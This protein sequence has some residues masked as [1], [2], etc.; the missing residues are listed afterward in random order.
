MFFSKNS[1]IQVR[2]FT[3]LF[4]L[5]PRASHSEIEKRRRQKLNKSIIELLDILPVGSKSKKP[6]K[7]T[8]LKIAVQH[9]R[10]L[11]ASNSILSD[12][13]LCQNYIT[14]L[15]LQSLVLHEGSNNFLI[16]IRL[17]SSKIIYVSETCTNCIG[18]KPVKYTKIKKTDSYKKSLRIISKK[19]FHYLLDKKTPTR[20]ID[21][22]KIIKIGFGYT[23]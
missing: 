9:M 13:F 23:F 22:S 7:I 21:R 11:K 1:S 5:S 19:Y 16:V 2:F 18:F 12:S 6:D 4:F 3:N 14:P 17:D 20:N 10:N 15:E 8:I